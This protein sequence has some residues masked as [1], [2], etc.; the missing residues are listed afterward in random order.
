MTIAGSNSP[1]VAEDA[2]S[3]AVYFI[4]T[5]SITESLLHNNASALT[6]AEYLLEG[7]PEARY[8]SVETQFNMLTTAQRDTLATID[9]GDTITVEKTFTSGAGTTELAQELAIEGIEHS[10][11]ITNGHRIALF[12]SPTTIVYE[13]ILDDAIYGILNAGNVLG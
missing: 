2:A 7:E 5:Q 13:L 1:Q 9:I 12:T 11:N 4:Q 10:I 6:L 8:T 3:Q